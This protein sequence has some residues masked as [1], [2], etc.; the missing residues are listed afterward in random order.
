MSDNQTFWKTVKSFF[1]DKDETISDND[2]ISEKLNSFFSDIVKNLNISQYEDH[3]VNTN[4]DTTDDP[5]LRAKEKFHQIIQL[6]QCR[7][8]NRNNTFC[9]SNIRHTEIEK[10]SNKLDFSKFSPNWDIPAKTVEDNI[11]IF[12]PILHT[13]H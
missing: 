10:E 8:E 12:T 4:T 5:I 1:T 2:E 11:D 9:F 13:Y 6:I 3:L 7:Y